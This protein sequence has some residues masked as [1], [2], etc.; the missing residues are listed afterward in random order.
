VNAEVMEILKNIPKD[1]VKDLI[2]LASKEENVEGIVKIA[3]D[4]GIKI[5]NEQ[6]EAVLKAFSE[7][8]AVSGDDLDKVSGG[9]SCGGC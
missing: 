1:K 8:V 6:A 9:S 5:T 2:Q 7:K 3:N 4:N